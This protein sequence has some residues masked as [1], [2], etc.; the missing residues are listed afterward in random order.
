MIQPTPIPPIVLPPAL[1][2]IEEVT[3]LDSDLHIVTNTTRMT[4]EKNF[5][6]VTELKVR[7]FIFISFTFLS[8]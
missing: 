3:S 8:V 5:E 4:K 2:N 1:T 6:M 7:I